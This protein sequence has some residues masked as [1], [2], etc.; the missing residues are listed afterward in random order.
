[1]TPVFSP[2]HFETP[3]VDVLLEEE[4]AKVKTKPE[5]QLCNPETPEDPMFFRRF[6]ECHKAGQFGP[7]GPASDPQTLGEAH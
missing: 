2:V 5:K 6:L 4:K 3:G 7:C 1:M